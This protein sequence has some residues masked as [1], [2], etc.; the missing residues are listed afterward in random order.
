MSSKSIHGQWLPRNGSFAQKWR[1]FRV[2]LQVR[3]IRTLL[4]R[5]KSWFFAQRL[6]WAKPAGWAIQCSCRVSGTCWILILPWQIGSWDSGNPTVDLAKAFPGTIN[7]LQMFPEPCGDSGKL[8]FIFRPFLVRSGALLPWF[9]HP[10]GWGYSKC[11]LV[12]LPDQFFW[13]SYFHQSFIQSSSIPIH[14][15]MVVFYINW[16]LLNEICITNAPVGYITWPYDMSNTT[17]LQVLGAF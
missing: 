3:T 1:G 12:A 17:Y 13:G 6:F 5:F 14:W 7:E 16:S 2:K 11:L 4:G 9:C 15:W 8:Y 10:G